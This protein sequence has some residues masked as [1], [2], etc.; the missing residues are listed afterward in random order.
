MDYVEFVS[1][2]RAGTVRAHVDRGRAMRVCSDSP[3]FPRRYRTVHLILKNTSLLLVLGGL[4]SLFW[5]PWWAGLGATVLGFAILPAVQKS[6][7]H[8]VLQYSLQDESFFRQMQDDGVLEVIDIGSP[9]LTPTSR[10]DCS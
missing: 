10:G 9:P 2:Y 6:A 3:A 1:G 4:I 5:I 7:A 8:F